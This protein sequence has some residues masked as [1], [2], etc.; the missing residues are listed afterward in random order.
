MIALASDHVGLALKM[1]IRSYLDELGI[2]WRDYGTE[3]ARQCDYPVFAQKAAQAV[4][5]GECV[6]GLLFC[7][8]GVGIG[9]A[10]NKIAGIRC[11]SCSDCYSAQLS[12]QHNN[13]N[14]LSLGSRVVGIELAKMIV[15]V[16]LETDFE[17]GR[18]Q[19]RIDQMTRLE[20]G[21]PVVEECVK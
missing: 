10:A 20:L 13:T 2:P 21:L 14:M 7:G 5:E 16:W 19:R 11:V 9:I 3:V 12:R 18:H 4:L 15:K 17:G 6:R 8:T 1:E